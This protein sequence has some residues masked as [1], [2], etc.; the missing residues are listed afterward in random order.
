MAGRVFPGGLPAAP[1]TDDGDDEVEDEQI[2]M[3]AFL[4]LQSTVSDLREDIE[5]MQKEK[6]EIE[7]RRKEKE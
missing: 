3:E 6:E 1:S 5:N 4:N 7:Q 2:S